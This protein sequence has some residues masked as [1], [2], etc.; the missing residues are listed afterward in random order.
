M[1]RGR[2]L[3]LVLD[4]CSTTLEKRMKAGGI[5]QFNKESWMKGIESAAKHL[6][7]LGLAHNDL[8]PANIM[9]DEYDNAIV[10]DLGSCK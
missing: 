1:K 5:P 9:L 2:I 4:R 6:H 3:G 7:T 8:S 10:I